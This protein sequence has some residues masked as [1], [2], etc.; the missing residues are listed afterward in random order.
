MKWTR[1][2]KLASG[3]RLFRADS[4]R[5]AL[6]DDSGD[7]PDQADDGALWLDVNRTLELHTDWLLIPV[8]NDT[9]QPYVVRAEPRDLTVLVGVYAN[10]AVKITPEARQLRDLVNAA[11]RYMYTPQSASCDHGGYVTRRHPDTGE[12][13]PFCPACGD[14][15]E[16]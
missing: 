5:Y 11:E 16:L 2:K 7:T 10:W 4:G 15:V 12:E 6:V 1:I 9:E 14:F 8:R 3:H 13:Q